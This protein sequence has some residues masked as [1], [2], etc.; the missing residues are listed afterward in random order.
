VDRVNSEGI[1]RHDLAHY[2][3]NRSAVMG[4]RRI[5][6]CML[7]RRLRVNEAGLCDYCYSALDGEEA[8]LAAAWLSGQGP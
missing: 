1:L 3:R 4:A 7:C 2:L 8:R 6:T 5:D